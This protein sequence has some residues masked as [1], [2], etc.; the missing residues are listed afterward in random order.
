MWIFHCIGIEN[1][2][3]MIGTDNQPTHFLDPLTYYLKMAL[4]RNLL[5][6]ASGEEG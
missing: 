1:Y 3:G 5:D 4:S 6:V 2:M